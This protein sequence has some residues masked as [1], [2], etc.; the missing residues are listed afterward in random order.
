MTVVVR[1]MLTPRTLLRVEGLAVFALSLLL[2]D[3]LHTGG[4]LLFV[5]LFLAPDVSMTGYAAGAKPGALIY[6]LV[7]TY[8][9]P[10]VLAGYGVLIHAGLAESLALIW[11]A[12]IGMD[13]ML[14][15]GLKYA[16]GFKDTHLG[17]V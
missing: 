8:L 9:G 2:Y 3:K 7:H 6:D 13:R 5:I 12:H 15:Y 10:I 14:G 1:D 17:R 4:W 16:T 11:S